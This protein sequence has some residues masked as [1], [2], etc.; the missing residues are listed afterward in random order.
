MFSCY[1]DKCIKVFKKGRSMKIK[2]FTSIILLFV[3][4]IFTKNAL[5]CPCNYPV[6]DP[7]TVDFAV[8]LVSNRM[9]QTNK[10]SEIRDAFLSV[11]NTIGSGSSM[12]S[13]IK[14]SLAEDFKIKNNYFMENVTL[15]KIGKKYGLKIMEDYKDEYCKYKKADVI[16]QAV[17]EFL[18]KEDYLT[19][20]EFKEK[21]EDARLLLSGASAEAFGNAIAVRSNAKQMEQ[22]KEDFREVISQTTSIR[23]SVNNS[24]LIAF[25]N[26]N[27]IQQMI[28]LYTNYLEVS[29]AVIIRE[30]TLDWSKNTE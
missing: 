12:F 22:T 17:R 8:T 6:T 10:I 1:Y 2:F 14:A 23:D 7:P 9:E 30:E 13:T 27:Y 19:H 18:K 16:K 4:V 28:D 3:L 26:A 21:I 25:S 11:F 20:E 15:N 24:N 29:T 5:S